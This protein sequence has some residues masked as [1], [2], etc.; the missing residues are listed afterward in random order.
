LE[1]ADGGDGRGVEAA[2]AGGT[3]VQVAAIGESFLYLLDG[4]RDEI[5]GS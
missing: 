5:I 3:E 4:A 2:R 1:L